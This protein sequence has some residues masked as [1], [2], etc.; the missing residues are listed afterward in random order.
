MG[1]NSPDIHRIIHLRPAE[2]VVS[3]VQQTGCTGT[4]RNPACTLPL[5]CKSEQYIDKEWLSMAQKLVHV[6]VDG[7]AFK[8]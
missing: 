8:D 3:Y 1:V 2:D 6:H 7:Y 5:Y 4:D